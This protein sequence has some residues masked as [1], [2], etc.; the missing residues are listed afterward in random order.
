M[1]DDVRGLIED[2]GWIPTPPQPT[3]QQMVDAYEAATTRIEEGRRFGGM[4]V[5]MLMLIAQDDVIAEV[6]HQQGIAQMN[7]RK[8]LP[9][10]RSPK[11]D[12]VMDEIEQYLWW[13][14]D[15]EKKARQMEQLKI[16]AEALAKAGFTFE[17]AVKALGRALH[18][19]MR[20]FQDLLDQ[21]EALAG[22]PALLKQLP[23]CPMHGRLMKGGRCPMCDRGSRNPGRTL[24]RR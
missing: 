11:S 17:S 10:A 24:G 14:K 12:H 5:E 7:A 20:P 23:A 13:Q 8:D 18:D 4:G 16:T 19:A 2:G 21:M 15:E 1:D 6:Q 9:T 22:K 3:Q